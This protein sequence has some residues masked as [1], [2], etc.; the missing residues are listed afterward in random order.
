P[1]GNASASRSKR[2][3]G[4]SSRGAGTD[5]SSV[6]R[7]ANGGRPGPSSHPDADESFVESGYSVNRAQAPRGRGPVPTR[8]ALS[9]LTKPRPSIVRVYR[10]GAQPAVNVT[11][12]LRPG[13][14]FKRSPGF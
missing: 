5:G 13:S 11:I 4:R 8:R 3:N 2:E 12:T 10:R 1:A 9:N 6:A 14:R 7:V